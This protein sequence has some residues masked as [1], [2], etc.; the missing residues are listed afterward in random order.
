MSSNNQN[1]TNLY[2]VKMD[3]PVVKRLGEVK[4]GQIFDNSNTFHPEG[5]FSTTIFGPVGSEQRNRTFGRISLN[6]EILHPLIYQTVIS[7]KS[8]YRRI[9]EGTATAVFDSKKGEF[10]ASNDDKADTGYA[11]FLKHLKELKFDKTDSEQRTYKIL[12]FNKTIKEDKAL[13]SQLLVMPAGMRDY[14]VDSNGRPQEDEVN[15]FYRRIIA[16]TAIIDP[17]QARRNP[18]I[19]N[20]ASMGLQRAVVDLYEHVKTFLDGKNK[21]IMDKWVGR[22][23]FNSTRNVISSY[24][25]KSISLND[26]RRLSFNETIAGL[27]QYA[28]SSAPKSLFEIKNKYIRDIFPDNSNSAFLTNKKTLKREEVLNTHILKDYDLWTSPEGL[29]KVIASLGNL[30]IRDL[31]V[32]L[33][34]GNHYLGLLYRD[35]KQF[36]FFQDID[37]LPEGF[38]KDKVSP[39]TLFEF[40]YMSIYAMDGQYPG[41][42]T[43][44]PITGYGSIYPT[45]I[46]IGTSVKTSTLVELDANWQVPEG[47]VTLATSFPVRGSEHINTMVI[48]QSHLATLDGDYD[49]DAM[50]LIMVLSDEAVSEVKSY[51]HRKDYYVSD[52]G[53]FIFSNNTDTLRAV[54]NYIT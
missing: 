13:I 11:F 9:M 4:T 52:S 33:N 16:Q 46:R 12:L 51:L 53:R 41:F 43:R 28:R 30:D 32:V 34:K 23:V 37:E 49:G 47:E 45:I 31:P 17:T 39:V 50:S 29:E 21:L 14:I 19:Y 8:F 24:V 54:L 15:T 3:D 18:S 10:F 2:I 38:S 25:D 20:S 26:K 27:H 6:T 35:N 5:L 42:A 22:K 7:L 48:H 1:F 36:K 44:Y 40:I